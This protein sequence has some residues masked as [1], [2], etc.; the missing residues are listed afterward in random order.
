MWSTPIKEPSRIRPDL[1]LLRSIASVHRE[2]QASAG[3]W[4][5]Y[6]WGTRLIRSF[7]VRTSTSGLPR[8]VR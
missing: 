8:I 2:S 4:D 5:T 6:V 3:I 7:T 1:P